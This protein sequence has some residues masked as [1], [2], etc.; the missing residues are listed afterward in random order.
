[1]FDMKKQLMWS[2]LK[3]GMVITCALLILFITVFFAGTIH[4]IFSPEVQIKAQIKDVKGLRR[5]SPVWLSGIEI[6][7]V[8]NIE[9]H[10]EAG[11]F[12]TM[13]VRRNAMPFIKKDSKATVLTMGLLG[14]KYVELS[15]G[16]SQSEP[17]T[18]GYVLAGSTQLEIQDLVN[19][20]AVSLAKITDFVE[21]LG[22]FTENFEKS[23]G[24]LAKFLTDPSIYNDMKET[25]STLNAI[26]KE[27][28]ESQGSLKMFIN[29]PSLYNKMVHTTSSL[30]E[31]SKK[32]NTGSGTLKMLLEDPTVYENLNKASKQLSSIMERIDRGEGLAGKLI[33]DKELSI[34]VKDTLVELKHSLKEF[35][36]LMIEIKEHPNRYFK[37]SVF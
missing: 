18:P 37:I 6:G 1:M 16:S 11:T 9:L 33:N 28:K 35:D 8:R 22:K 20:S 30:E 34:E 19:A 10:P 23:K 15:S 2:K 3:V 21:K 32:L 7:S 4:N 26:A 5:G 31:F 25:T 12:V 29:D 14:D 27:F 36:E 24:T 17:V 13:T